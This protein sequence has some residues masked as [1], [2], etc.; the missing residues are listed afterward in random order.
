MA[1][2]GLAPRTI[3]RA[4]AV[5]GRAPREAEVAGLVARN[6]ARLTRP[7]SVRHE[8][9]RTLSGEQARA[10]IDAAKGG[11]LG[12]LYAVALASG[13]REGEL[14]EL[15]WSDIDWERSAVKIRRTLQRMSSAL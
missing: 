7:P 2:K 3:I 8:E 10:L 4:R 1:D 5:L 14:F 15:R 9:M 11:R 13:A 12:A 6:A